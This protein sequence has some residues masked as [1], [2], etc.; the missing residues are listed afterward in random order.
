MPELPTLAHRP[1]VFCG[2][3][4]GSVFLLAPGPASRFWKISSKDR[5]GFS[6]GASL[7]GGHFYSRGDTKRFLT[8]IGVPTTSA[9]VNQKAM[10]SQVSVMSHEK[11]SFATYLQVN[12]KSRASYLSACISPRSIHQSLQRCANECRSFPNLRQGFVA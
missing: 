9:L 2:E 12:K 10:S 8:L 3:M 7:I 6:W 1:S 11:S 5:M 4:R